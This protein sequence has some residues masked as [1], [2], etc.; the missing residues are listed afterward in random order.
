MAGTV[1]SSLVASQQTVTLIH[2]NNMANPSPLR[3]AIVGGG[4]GGLFFAI[5][6]APFRHIQIDIYEGAA[7]FET[8]G[9]GLGIWGDSVTACRKLGIE[10]RLM[11]IAPGV[12]DPSYMQLR[13]ANRPEGHH[14]GDVVFSGIM[15]FH[16]AGFLD[17]LVQILNETGRG[18]IC[19][20][21]RCVSYSQS[22]SS[23]E[24]TIIFKD[25]SIATCDCLIGCDGIKSI[26]RKQLVE[27]LGWSARD[28][29]VDPFQLRFTGTVAYRALI[30]PETLGDHPARK[31]K[32]TYC[33]S[34]KHLVS[35]PVAGGKFINLIAYSSNPARHDEWKN[36]PWTL[37]SEDGSE[38]LNEFSDLEAEVQAMLRVTNRTSRWALYEVDPLP[39]WSNGRVAVLGD[40]AH[41]MPPFIG[42]GGGQVIEDGYVL[43][44][45]LGDTE[46]TRKDIPHILHS[47][48]FIRKERAE[49]VLKSTREAKRA[50]ESLD[51]YTD[52]SDEHIERT[53]NGLVNWLWQGKLDLDEEISR[54][55]R[56]FERLRS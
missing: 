56:E 10:E 11:T 29:D 24:V 43:A 37:D 5:A 38:V 23:E 45:L 34:H 44:Q 47:Y 52:A 17:L 7:K 28:P 8:I 50:Y 20:G 14:L 15:G 3:V 13:R 55:R 40:A 33:G 54:G 30:N 4:I 49:R 42:A 12:E 1:R 6:L 35:Y 46:L 41:A 19:F 26:V 9:A 18:N 48:G 31:D 22:E 36:G 16:R 51:E 2:P 25:G 21:K 32:K 39:H 27:E 53:V